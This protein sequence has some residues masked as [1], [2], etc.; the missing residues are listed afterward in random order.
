MAQLKNLSLDLLA[1]KN[2]KDLSNKINEKNNIS[3]NYLKTFN[4]IQY[5][6][7]DL[8]KKIDEK[9]NKNNN[10]NNLNHLFNMSKKKTKNKNFVF[11]N[12]MN[13]TMKYN[14]TKTNNI[15][16]NSTS[17]TNKKNKHLQTK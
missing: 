11:K 12:L 5:Q 7:G 4:Q 3:L 13:L 16:N 2:L 10:K 15:K 14:N 17:K 8:Y 1:D 6:N 9:D